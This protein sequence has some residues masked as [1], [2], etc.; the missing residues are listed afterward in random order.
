MIQLNDLD[1]IIALRRDLHA[2]PETAYTEVRTSKVVEQY[3][4]N[5]G[6]EV[7]TGI[8]KT[9]VVGVLKCGSS[10]RAI[11]LRADMD[12]LPMNEENEFAHRS[13]VSGKMHGC[14]HDGHTAMLLAAASYLKRQGGFNGTIYFNFQPAEENGHCGARA[15][16]KDGLF[17]RFP[18]DAVFG[19]HNWP[20]MP[21]G[22]F[23]IRPGPLMASAN[24]FRVT[25]EGRGGHASAPQDCADPVPALLEIGQAIQT[26]LTRNKRP[27]DAAVISITQMQAG[28]V[29]ANVIPRS[30]WLGGS[31]RAFSA[32]VV[33]LIERR[34]NELSSH[35]AAA[36]GCKAEV[37]FERRSPP[38]INTPE[39]TE[40]CTEVM[41]EV[42]G[43]TRAL[44]VDPVMASEDFSFYLR[45]KPACYVF[46][47]AGFGDHRASGHGLGPC[48]LHNGSYDFND[49]LI[50]IG[51]SYWIRLAQTYLK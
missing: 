1:S 34:L 39:L 15:M 5:C 21:E 6:M 49:N 46:L 19:M 31:I 50:P 8:A 41:H 27:L 3:L 32:D 24:A 18:A 38:V 45:E 48:S 20:G 43:P 51:A 44:V 9:G 35:I 7:H 40:L 30:C 2:N 10:D 33:D 13:Q 16:M 28:G 12:A 47:G 25:V 4:K 11:M 29:A 37:M 23:G 42:V 17:E 36:H 22:S 26:I 14:G